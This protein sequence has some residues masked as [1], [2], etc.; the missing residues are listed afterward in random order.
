M[1]A[2]PR[3]HGRSLRPSIADTIDLL[4]WVAVS[5]DHRL[6]AVELVQSQVGEAAGKVNAVAA[7]DSAADHRA[8][9]RRSGARAGRMRRLFT[10]RNVALD[11]A[12]LPFDLLMK[13]GT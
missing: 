9:Y 2:Q 8:G 10:E 7:T 5:R 1:A 11:F 3:P 13:T 6:D 12:E 4:S